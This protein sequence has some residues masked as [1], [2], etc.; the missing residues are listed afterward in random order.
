ML[1][2]FRGRPEGRPR[3]VKA[4]PPDVLKDWDLDCSKET[5]PNCVHQQTFGESDNVTTSS[6]ARIA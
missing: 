5:A 6:T 1:S 4:A 2:Q 3:H